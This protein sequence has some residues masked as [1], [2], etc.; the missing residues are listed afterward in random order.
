MAPVNYYAQNGGSLTFKI[1]VSEEG[2]PLQIELDQGSS[3]SRLDRAIKEALKQ[4][5]YIPA[6]V[7]GV[8][9]QGWFTFSY[10]HWN[11]SNE[12]PPSP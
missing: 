11:I 5:E 9:S 7:D 6:I 10:R 1:L 8:P 3:N 2:E 4:S 12:T